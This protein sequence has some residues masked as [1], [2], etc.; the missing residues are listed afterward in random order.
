MNL[1]FFN[2]LMN[3]GQSTP[4]P[5]LL[6]LQQNAR[7]FYDFTKLTGADG[8]AITSVTD[9]GI[10][11]INASNEAPAQDPVLMYSQW[12]AE[13][14]P[15]F[16]AWS[17]SGTVKREV[18]IANTTGENIFK[19]DFE[20]FWTGAVNNESD[21]DF[22]GVANG[23]NVF[24]VNVIANKIRFEYRYSAATA[25]RFVAETT[26]TVYT[27]STQ[28]GLRLYRAK[29]DFTN[30]VFKFWID[31]VEQAMTSLV[32]AFNL[33]DPTKWANATYKLGVGGY[34]NG[35]TIVLYSQYHLMKNFVVAPIVPDE[36]VVNT[37]DY[38]MNYATAA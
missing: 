10:L 27:A 33:I 35:G 21:K 9:L 3:G 25:R 6:W 11:G 29:F 17:N 20:I 36:E 26:S 31:G 4:H 37:S 28:T 38:L 5:G 13:M 18:L 19:S 23:T 2:L 1:G 32:D 14:I 30:D 22:F 34:N 7:I 15:T 12:G 24:R 8:A 16:K